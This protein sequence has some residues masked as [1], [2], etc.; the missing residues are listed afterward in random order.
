MTDTAIDTEVELYLSAFTTSVLGTDVDIH[1][2]EDTFFNP[3]G[4][5][6]SWLVGCWG[7]SLLGG[8]EVAGAQASRE[9]I[10]AALAEVGYTR[11]TQWSGLARR[12][13]DDSTR[14]IAGAT[15]RPPH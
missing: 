1:E 6:Y 15:A 3:D 10:D 5:V 2:T 11:T 4:S 12:R 9:Q 14:Y 13:S 7:E 8:S